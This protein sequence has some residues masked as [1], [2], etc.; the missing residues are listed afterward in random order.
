M[1]AA[2]YL[3]TANALARDARPSIGASHSPRIAMGAIGVFAWLTVFFTVIAPS[4]AWRDFAA[5]SI[6]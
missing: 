5:W 1:D 3:A 6:R 2:T 4:S